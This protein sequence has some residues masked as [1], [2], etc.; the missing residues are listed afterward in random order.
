MGCGSKEVQVLR[1]PRG[2]LR[3]RDGRRRVAT[4]TGEDDGSAEVDTTTKHHSPT[5]VPWTLQL[6]LVV[7]PHVR[8][9]RSTTTREAQGTKGRREGRKQSTRGMECKRLGSFRKA[10]GSTGEGP[11]VVQSGS[12][13]AIWTADRCLRLRSRSCTGAVPQPYGSA[14]IGGDCEARS[15]KTSRIHEP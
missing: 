13:E 7:R 1:H 11:T 6:L 9:V 15:L 4:C 14:T 10:E 3:T 2:V 5:C 8:G 12:H